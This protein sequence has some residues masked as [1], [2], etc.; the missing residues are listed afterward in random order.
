[1]RGRQRVRVERA[2]GGVAHALHAHQGQGEGRTSNPLRVRWG[3][4]RRVLACQERVER[5]THTSKIYTHVT[6]HYNRCARRTLVTGGE[7]CS[8]GTP[9]LSL[10]WAPLRAL[11]RHARDTQIHYEPR[12]ELAVVLYGSIRACLRC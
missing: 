10:R 2:R 4:Y 5:E 12:D 8:E 1:M 7:L 9:P 11:S 3:L 6:S